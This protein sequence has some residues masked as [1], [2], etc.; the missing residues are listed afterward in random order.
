[1]IWHLAETSCVPRLK[2]SLWRALTTL[3]LAAVILLS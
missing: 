2:A 1:M 3:S